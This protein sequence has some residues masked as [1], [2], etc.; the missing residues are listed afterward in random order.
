MKCANKGSNPTRSYR[1]IFIDSDGNQSCQLDIVAIDFD[2]IECWANEV[3]ERSADG[4]TGVEIWRD[5]ERM[6][7]LGTAIAAQPAHNGRSSPPLLAP[8]QRHLHLGTREF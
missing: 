8:V 4:V 1:C 5:G 2:H 6:A 7:L 3:I